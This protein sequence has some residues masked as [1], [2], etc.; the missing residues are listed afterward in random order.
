[1]IFFLVFIFNIN[2]FSYE[3]N[4]SILYSDPFADI[5]GVSGL[6]IVSKTESLRGSINSSFLGYLTKNIVSFSFSND[7]YKTGYYS[8]IS[9]SIKIKKDAAFN[10]SYYSYRSGSDDFYLSDELKTT[11]DFEK[12]DIFQFSIGKSF[13]NFSFGF[14]AKFLNSTLFEKYNAN[15]FMFD[16]DFL[17]R[18]IAG[19]DIYMGFE[20]LG[21]RLKYIEENE[22]LPLFYKL[23][24]ARDINIGPIY[25]NVGWG[26]KKSKNYSSNS[27]GLWIGMINFPLEICSGYQNIVDYGNF[28]SGGLSI[29]FENFYISYGIEL[30]KVFE[31][32]IQKISISYLF[33]NFLLRDN[34]KIEKGNKDN[35]FRKTPSN[36]KKEKQK[37]SPYQEIIIF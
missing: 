16:F 30:T 28:Y 36:K 23:E 1:M 9:S 3:S 22:N 12:D 33:D 19:F 35:N 11:I 15:T 8:I 21:G 24:I 25:L 13:N 32:N 7:Y 26:I 10:F 29:G 5:K 4:L 2:L 6:S 34:N 31:K 18:K 37:T 27:F 17:L 14:K 20:N